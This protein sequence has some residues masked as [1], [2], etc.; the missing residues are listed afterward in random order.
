MEHL[1]ESRYNF[2][3]TVALINF[4]SPPGIVVGFLTEPGYRQKIMVRFDPHMD[5]VGLYELEI[6]L[7][8][9]TG[10]KND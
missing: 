6:E 3:D 10:M 1:Q 7:C 5:P 2:G 8:G 4:C 9:A